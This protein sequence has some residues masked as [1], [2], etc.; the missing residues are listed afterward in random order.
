MVGKSG[1]WSHFGNWNFDRAFV[2]QAIKE[3]GASGAVAIVQEELGLT[4]AEASAI[5]FEA[6]GLTDQQANSWI[7]P[8]AGYFGNSDFGCNPQG[9]ILVCTFGLGFGN[10]AQ[11][12]QVLE[13]VFFDL[14]NASNTTAT[15]GVY[16]QARRRLGGSDI[17]PQGIVYTADDGLERIGFS[18]Q[19]LP[20]DVIIDTERNRAV[21]ANPSV[22]DSTMTKLFYL[23][24][25]YMDSFEKLTEQ[26]S[27]FGNRIVI[28]KVNWPD[29]LRE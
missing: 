8:F 5:V 19:T 22:S 15:V 1:V 18:G 20:V 6:N 13:R 10:S 27:V 16:D 2:Y 7:S 23:D 9:E 14:T 25:K 17:K 21:L 26:T 11:G 29:E 4:E 28:W 12:N 24:G 3:S